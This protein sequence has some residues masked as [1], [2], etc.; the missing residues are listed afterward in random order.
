MP[1]SSLLLRAVLPLL[2]AAIAM[3]MDAS[4]TLFLY[5]SILPKRNRFR[6]H[7]RNQTIWVTGASSGIGLELLCLLIEAQTKHGAFSAVLRFF[8]VDASL[9]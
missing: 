2:V 7:F 4:P 1:S 6:S 9:A 3:V 8:L 5:D